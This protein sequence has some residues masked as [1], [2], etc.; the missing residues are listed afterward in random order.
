MGG[1][2]SGTVKNA[3]VVMIEQAAVHYTPGQPVATIICC[4]HP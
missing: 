3:I 4:V 2:G 1:G